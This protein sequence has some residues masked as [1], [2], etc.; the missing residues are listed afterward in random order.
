MSEMIE[1]VYFNLDEADRQAWTKEFAES[2]RTFLDRLFPYLACVVPAAFLIAGFA[3]GKDKPNH[4]FYLGAALGG[5]LQSLAILWVARQI[6][7]RQTRKDT[8]PPNVWRVDPLRVR[9]SPAGLT[10]EN[11]WATSLL[12]DRRKRV[13]MGRASSRAS[14]SEGN[15]TSVRP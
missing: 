10:E 9:I 7:K 4:P 11:Q 1:T 12:Q 13:A 3:V 6:Q 14:Q 5:F 15:L 2:R 8:D